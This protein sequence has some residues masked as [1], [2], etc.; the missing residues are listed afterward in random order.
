MVPHIRSGAGS[1]RFTSR[2]PEY[3]V[4]VQLYPFFNGLPSES[5]DDYIF[6][7]E[8]L[9][10]RYKD[11]EKKLIGP[12]L[13]RRR[14]GVPCA[15]AWRELHMPDLVK[16]EGFKLIIVF[17]EKKGIQEGCSGQATLRESR[18]RDHLTEARDTLNQARRG[19]G[20]WPVIAI[21]AAT[22]A[23]QNKKHTSWWQGK[24]QQRLDQ[25]GHWQQKRQSWKE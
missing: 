12:R 13:V 16:P 3:T 6:E 10:A 14:G 24:R 19:R 4:D 23:V 9:A 20:F 18:A 15:L 2:M 11:D 17:L 1:D 5:L 21:R 7:V 8:A 25:L 22:L